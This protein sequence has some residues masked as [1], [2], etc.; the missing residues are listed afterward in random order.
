MF[1]FRKKRLLN[2]IINTSCKNIISF[3]PENIFYLTG[4]WGEG[5]VL[6]NH[7]TTKLYTPK[8]E[9]FRALEDTK[10][11]EIIKT[12]R[13]SDALISIIS[14]LDNNDYYC[15]DNT[16]YNIINQLKEK[17]GHDKIIVNDEPF[18]QTRSIKDESEINNTRKAANII[19]NLYKI[20][21]EKIKEGMTEREL[22]S[23]LVYE[24]FKMGGGFPAY[25]STLNPFIIAS[26]INSAFPHA[27]VSEKKFKR[28]DFI[29][30]DLTLRF[31]GYIA[32]ATRTF[33]LKTIDPEMDKI[34][35]I[36]KEAQTLGL[37]KCSNKI[38]IGEVDKTC[39]D[40][41]SKKGFANE[42]N[43]STGHGIGLDVHEPPWIRANNE[44]LL[45]D[46]MTITIE[47]GIYF[48]S[49]YGVRIEDSII[50]DSH[51][52]TG[53]INLNK[54]DKDLIVI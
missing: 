17:I 50:I 1:N 46:N 7:N 13:G 39:R 11:C 38:K 44:E 23:I 40:Y 32:D 28:G 25:K 49:K 47:P 53:I 9:Y 16:N 41:I 19:D 27:N 29:I 5:I 34:Y 20:C 15:I 4:F 52:K 45:M 31:N 35:N 36:V 14:E 3:Q 8:L 24:T 12:E 37:N 6:M 18:F 2:N 33:A 10:D 26:G 21:Q 51:K 30:V 43:H 42:F 22:Q 48:E 54:F